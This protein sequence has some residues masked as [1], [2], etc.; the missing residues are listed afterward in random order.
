MRIA[1]FNLE[2]FGEERLR[3]DGLKPRIA[4]LRPELVALGADVLC[5]QEVNGQR[6]MPE[7]PRLLAALDALLDETPYA[8]YHRAVSH[9]IDD[10][11]PA[12][13]HN[14]VVLSRFPIASARSIWFSRIEPPLWRPPHAKPPFAVPEP[15]GFDRPV[16]QVEIALTGAAAE[17]RKLHIF[18]VHLRAPVAAA[19]PGGK[20]TADRWNSVS[21]WAEGLFLSA[22]KRNA[23]ALELRLA[24]EAI[25][26]GEAEPLIAVAGD[27]NADD[28]EPAIRLVAADPE[29]TGSPAFAARRMIVLD[30]AI[31]DRAR[32]SVRHHGVDR[33]LDH[34]LASPALAE[35]LR[36][37]VVRNHDLGDEVDEAGRREGSYHA[38]VVAEFQ[39]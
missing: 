33:M 38:A 8:G 5:L 12:D 27:F 28:T 30:D 29:E 21:A 7:G 24:L 23:Q 9:R 18:T 1:S 2:S 37:I 20:A 6:E 17:G 34:I 26:D 13:R 14:L 36:S 11:G 4:A 16:L 32:H 3:P 19:F 22:L 10:S 35:Q 31:P 25:F 39:L 15:L